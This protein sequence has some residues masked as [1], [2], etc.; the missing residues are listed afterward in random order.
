SA[1]YVLTVGSKAVKKLVDAG[2]PN[3][4]P[5]W[6]PDGSRIAYET[7]NG[8][9][10]FYYAN[11]VIAV[12][13]A[14]GGKPEV[15]SEA[16]DE[17]PG[18]R[19]WAPEGIYFTGLQKTAAYLFRLEPATKEIT[20]LGAPNPLGYSPV[21]F[22]HDYRR[23]AFLQGDPRRLPEVC[24]A[25]LKEYKPKRL[26]T[27]G[28]QLKPYRTASREVIQWKSTD[29]TPIEGIL[30]KPADFDPGKRY[31]L[32]V[33]IHPGPE[34]VDTPALFA[35]R[36]YPLERFAARG[37]L[38]LRPNYRGSAGYGAKFRALNVRNLGCGDYQDVISGVDHLVGRGLVDHNRVGA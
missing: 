25:D 30:M 28:D 1:I 15:L 27:L 8:Q 33:V 24:V 7:A 10:F 18:L 19:E 32:L 6:S 23:I 5:V 12:V 31:P 36:Y 29:G 38:I 22:T 14:G 9:E 2:G 13:P 16:F 3:R 35:D 4:G 26:T 11:R 20:R 37:A 34:G 17:Q 21:S